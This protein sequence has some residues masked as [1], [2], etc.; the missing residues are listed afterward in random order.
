[1]SARPPGKSWLKASSVS[2]GPAHVSSL[3]LSH[4]LEAAYS[5]NLS[6]NMRVDLERQQLE[7]TVS[8]MHNP[9]FTVV[10]TEARRS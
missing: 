6:S 3:L 7:P 8:D 10:K 4:W 2:R 9:H 1:M 5:C